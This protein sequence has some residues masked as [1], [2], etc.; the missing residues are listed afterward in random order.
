MTNIDTKNPEKNMKILWFALTFSLCIMVGVVFVLSRNW[1]N[2]SLSLVFSG[3]QDFFFRIIFFIALFLSGLSLS[4][5]YFFS[6]NF[7]KANL[8]AA[9]FQIKILQWALSESVT[10]LG[11]IV[12]FLTQNFYYIFPFFTLSLVLNV[13]HFPN[14]EKFK[15]FYSR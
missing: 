10:M 3:Q 12:C 4:I 7:V 15:N 9:F 6:K 14:L 5:A 8:N 1:E 11:F 13:Y 2:N